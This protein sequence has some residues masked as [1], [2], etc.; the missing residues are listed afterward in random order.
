MQSVP[1]VRRHVIDGL[2]TFIAV[3][4]SEI[5]H[6]GLVID[7]G[8]TD[9]TFATAGWLRL[10]L[11]GAL[12]ESDELGVRAGAQIS[13]TRTVIQLTGE[14][15]QVAR[16]FHTISQRLIRPDLKLLEALTTPIAS[17]AM[18]ERVTAADEALSVRFGLNG[19]ALLAERPPMGLREGGQLGIEEFAARFVE[20]GDCRGY[21]DFEPP[22]GWTHG[23]P[24]G[25]G[26]PRPVP[27]TTLQVPG[28]FAGAQG[29]TVSGIVPRTHA[30]TAFAQ[31]ARQELVDEF[32]TD[33]AEAYAPNASYLRLDS[34]LAVLVLDADL[35]PDRAAAQLP[36]LLELT[37]RWTK[38]FNQE[39]FDEM[40]QTVRNLDQG[41]SPA[42]AAQL[43][44]VIDLSEPPGEQNWRQLGWD[45]VTM[46]EIQQIA[47]QFRASLLLGL[48]QPDKALPVWLP[49]ASYV[50]P[51]LPNLPTQ[52]P[53]VHYPDDPRSAGIVDGMLAIAG[54]PTT[55]QT[56]R[57]DLL[58]G[59]IEH[60]DGA[61][62]VRQSTGERL[63][64]DP[65][66]WRDGDALRDE[67]VRIAGPGRLF[68]GRERTPEEQQAS[69]PSVSPSERLR[70]SRQEV[71]QQGRR[72]F[73]IAGAL[74]ILPFVF[75]IWAAETEIVHP[76]VALLIGLP[77]IAVGVIATI[78]LSHRS[79]NLRRRG[80][81][82]GVVNG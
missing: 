5:G 41:H 66:A 22:A 67:I 38:G 15:E 55:Q 14:P 34:D 35:A 11:Q 37:Q 47:E 59:V 60:P 81:G 57:L 79:R 76:G 56:I 12:N 77:I 18:R 31:L 50:Q 36:K 44:A 52:H 39:R 6:A 25:P 70:Q 30:A 26:L 33:S 72:E 29:L 3:A 21:L 19:P 16:A 58:A 75:M 65:R 20:T 10:L 46:P 43:A 54:G 13:D 73:W 7:R 2:I 82:G 68:V 64:L 61:V 1:T 62:T 71:R 48:P 42:D 17:G 80:G 4:D 27:V 69:A 8:S 51:V 53:S 78:I 9:E 32:R 23:L 63:V 40:R 74:V 24:Q 45:D 49:M 28:W